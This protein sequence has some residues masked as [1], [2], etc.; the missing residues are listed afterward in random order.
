MAVTRLLRTDFTNDQQRRLMAVVRSSFGRCTLGTG[1]KRKRT[2][3]RSAGWRISSGRKSARHYVHL[4]LVRDI[5]RKITAHHKISDSRIREIVQGNLTTHA[6]RTYLMRAA[7]VAAAD[8]V[9]GAFRMSLLKRADATLT[10]AQRLERC[11]AA[12]ITEIDSGRLG[13]GRDRWKGSAVDIIS[14]MPS[15]L[16]FGPQHKEREEDHGI[17]DPGDELDLTTVGQGRR[18]RY[19]IRSSGLVE[20]FVGS[21]NKGRTVIDEGLW[22]G[23]PHGSHGIPPA[24]AFYRGIRRVTLG[25]FNIDPSQLVPGTLSRRRDGNRSGR[26]GDNGP[27]WSKKK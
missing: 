17:M 16:Q 10:K 1:I 9:H 18:R 27:R 11:V 25:S 5:E 15:N 26:L 20:E 2:P 21:L 6:S 24:R 7:F 14:N 8:H 4:L 23:A 19:S 22:T 3:R 13:T 12:V